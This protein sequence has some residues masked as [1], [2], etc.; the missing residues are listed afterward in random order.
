MVVLHKKT[1]REIKENKG[2]YLACMV[3]IVIGLMVFTSMSIVLENLERAQLDFYQATHFADGFIRLTGYPENKV[4]SLTRISGVDAVEGRIVKDVSIFDE[5]RD[6]TRSLRL[7]SL[8]PSESSGLNQL[9]LTSGRLPKDTETEILVDPKF[10]TANHLSL[11]ASLTLILEGKRA[12]FTVVGTAQSPEFIYAMKTAQDFYPDPKT[13]GIAYVPL[14]SLKTLVKESGQVNDLIFTL[15]PGADFNT[16]KD[17]LQSELKRY[18]VQSIIPRKDQTSDAILSNEL[19]SLK[20]TTRTLPVVFLG[21]ATIILYT[22]LRRLVEQQRVII[23]TMKAYGFTNREIILHYLSYPLFI[24]GLGGLLG[25]LAGIALSYPLTSLYEEYFALPGLKSSFSLKYLFLGIALSL[26]FSLLSGIKGSLDIL[27]LDPAQAMRPVA[28]G[29]T[30]K[31]Q[32]ER[33]SWFWKALSSQAQMGLRNVFRAPA[34]SLFTILGMAVIYSLMTVSWSM[35]N[36]TDKLT[37]FQF[38][39]V[40][41]YDVKLSLTRPGPTRATQYTLAHEPGISKVEPALEVPATLKNQW[42]KKEVVL[43]GLENNS[44]LYNILDKNNQRV[45]I[46]ASG[47]LLSE[48]LADLLQVKTGDSLT[49]ESPLRRELIGQKEQ[50]LTVMGIV[51][52][53]VGLNAF[54]DIQTLQ[55]F[56]QQ[57]EIST[58][59]FI[60]MA[61]EDVNL[62]KYKYRDASQV[63]SIE[64]IK[65]SKEKILEM[66]KSTGFTI[67]FLAILAGIA[68]FALIYNSSIISLSE[69]QRELASLRVLGLTPKE[70]LR[71]ITSEQ[72]TLCLLGILIGIPLSYG[73]L[74]GMSQA[75]S[76]D[77]YSLPAELPPYALVEAALGTT[78]SVWIAQTRAHRKIKSLPFVEILATKE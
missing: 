55:H 46:P 63:S 57:G 16:V 14:S 51:P 4:Q 74:A 52:Q 40:Q 29:S 53:Y 75:L 32:L 22:M 5:E 60:Q 12:T 2:V 56:L 27:R 11:G 15:Q 58:S 49:V 26:T 24:G 70:V 19:T 69:R 48:H 44:T 30:R 68:G 76:T 25:G 34:R 37:T 77:L 23:G 43:M 62:L 35:Q 13:F 31:T 50:P 59:L 9:Q 18:G 54:M 64:S 6:V 42:H 33:I 67:Y 39:N 20:G 1:L 10:Y 7:A 66:M 17:S 47:L 78:F 45:E 73:L 71:V 3:V 8:N 61:P 38:D 72:W 41:K 28:P 21:V 65:E 36:M